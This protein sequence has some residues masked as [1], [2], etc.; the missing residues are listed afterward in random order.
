MTS[1]IGLQ[2]GASRQYMSPALACV[3]S[4]M[5]LINGIMWAQALPMSAAQPTGKTIALLA[6]AEFEQFVPTSGTCFCS[7]YEVI[8]CSVVIMWLPRMATTWSCS[9]IFCVM[10]RAR[11]G[12]PPSSA[13]TSLTG[14][15]H[16]PP[17]SPTDAAQARTPSTEAAMT[18]PITPLSWPRE[19]MATGSFFGEQSAPPAAAGA[20][21]PAG[22]PGA[23]VTDEG[24]PALPGA[25]CP[26]AGEAALAAPLLCLG[27]AAVLCF[28]AAALP[29]AAAPLAVGAAG[30]AAGA[31]APLAAGDCSGVAP[32]GTAAGAEVTSGVGALPCAVGAAA[33]ELVPEPLSREPQPAAATRAAARMAA[34]SLRRGVAIVVVATV[35]PL[36]CSGRV[37]QEWA[38]APM[39]WS[40]TE[41]RRHCSGSPTRATRPLWRT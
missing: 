22:V 1:E 38:P 24:P 7:R 18:A 41:S 19:P 13:R 11:A 2:A 34:V 20:P 14:W 15:P 39:Y 32:P 36:W 16:S 23:G 35:V 3:S 37:G 5:E 10:A 29:A 40:K 30:E 26:P 25:F 9:T 27:A 17:R 28:G 8:A 33:L 31:P 6:S 21:C 4:G 12:S